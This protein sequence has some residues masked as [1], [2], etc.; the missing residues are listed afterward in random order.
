MAY[1]VREVTIPTGDGG[2]RA[3]LGV[4]YALIVAASK[5]PNV[6]DMAMNIMRTEKLKPSTSIY[7]LREWIRLVVPFVRDP[8][9]AEALTDPVAMIARIEEQ[10][11]APGDCDDVAMLVAAMALA[12]GFRARLAV[13]GFRG[14]AP[15]PLAAGLDS[16]DPFLHIWCEVASPTGTLVWTEMDTTRP[17]QRIPMDALSRIWIV[18]IPREG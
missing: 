10:G 15:M 9:T 3:T 17:M 2:T 7:A 4:M 12:V 8:V 18:P 1:T 5:H 16:A 13:V 11:R 6:R 14:T